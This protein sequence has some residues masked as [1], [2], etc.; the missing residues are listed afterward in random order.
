MFRRT[1]GGVIEVRAEPRPVTEPYMASE[2]EGPAAVSGGRDSAGDCGRD[3]GLRGNMS[4]II[5]GFNHKVLT[6]IEYRAVSGV[7]RT[8]PSPTSVCVLPP[9]QRQGGGGGTQS[10]G[11]EGVGGGGILT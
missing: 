8:T 5:N 7:F 1:G 2:A 3:I 6:Y 10:P 9:L 4:T 11:S